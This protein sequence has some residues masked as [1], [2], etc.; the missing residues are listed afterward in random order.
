MIID[1]TRI[2][3][4]P[5]QMWVFAAGVIGKK[6]YLQLSFSHYKASYLIEGSS[7]DRCVVSTNCYVFDV[8]TLDYTRILL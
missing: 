5:I 2:V 7:V 6:M 1:Q 3:P 4:L 8:E